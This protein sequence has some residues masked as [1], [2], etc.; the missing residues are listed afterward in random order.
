M[1][2]NEVSTNR[3]TGPTVFG[4]ARDHMWVVIAIVVV[5]AVGAVVLSRARAER[6]TAEA[7]IILEDPA[8]VD[9][10]GGR[11]TQSPERLVANQIAVLRSG[12]VARRASELVS[13]QGLEVDPGDIVENA[14]FLSSRDSDQIVI[15]FE[16]ETEEAAVAVTQAIIDAYRE[17]QLEQRRAEGVR[18]LGRLMSAREVLLSDLEDVNAG[19]DELRAGRQLD[20][21]TFEALDRLALVQSQL[22]AATNPEVVAELAAQVALIGDQI[23]ILQLG[24]DVEES[25]PD[26]A[27]LL[28]NR[29]QI[30]GQLDTISSRSAELE[31]EAE[32]G[33]SGIAFEDSAAVVS[34]AGGVG[35][36]FTLAAGAFLGLLVALGVA[37]QLA[38][39]RATYADRFE[40]S[41]ETGLQLLGDVPVFADEVPIP[42][43][44]DPRSPGAEAMRFAVGN[45]Q[46]AL[47]R[48]DSKTVMFVSTGVGEGKSTLLANVALASARAG[49]KVLVIDADFGNQQTSALLLGTIPDGPGLTELGAGRLTLAEAV[50]AADAGMGATVDVLSRGM[51]PI[52]AP[53]FFAS[54]SLPAIIERISTVYNLVVID[55]PPMLQVAYA[56]N[57]AQMAKSVV[58]VIS[59]GSSI[60]KSHELVDRLR[61]MDVEV[62][63]YIYNKA[64]LRSEFLESG[65]SMRDVLGDRGFE[66]PV[67]GRKKR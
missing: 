22:A 47:D 55:G 64:P 45:L 52:M 60:S 42:V 65:G 10:L 21:L 11:V 24:V 56:N 48:T 50:V 46:L 2:D 53:E 66:A 29:D 49:S 16:A 32:S 1:L 13:A 59:H 25:D 67:E 44:D 7:V 17:V 12:V 61:F 33:T 5:F 58:A 30:R 23:E 54:R 18:V 63:G 8:S 20:R 57:V 31:V 51:M 14:E 34:G 35:T 62:L 43:R 36:L 9:V 26:M 39:R 6:V 41:R 37:Y 15:T 27:A 3:I 19:I 40:P 38:G 28:R 4:A